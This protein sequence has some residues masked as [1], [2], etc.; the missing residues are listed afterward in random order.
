M[1]IFES[2]LTP[3]EESFIF[4]RQLGSIVN[5]PKTNLH[6]QIKF[7][8]FKIVQIHD[9]IHAVHIF[10]CFFGQFWPLNMEM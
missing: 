5:A 6:T 7:Y 8:K 3:Y 10:I 9:K 2:L 4:L 1:I